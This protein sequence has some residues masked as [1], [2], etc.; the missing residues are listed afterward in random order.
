MP[1][2][3]KTRFLAVC[4]VCA[5]VGL[6]PLVGSAAPRFVEFVFPR[7]GVFLIEG[8]C[9]FPLLVE[10]HGFMRI[11]EYYDSA[12]NLTMVKIDGPGAK[13]T[14]TNVETGFS[15]SSPVS[16]Q[17]ILIDPDRETVVGLPFRLNVPGSGIVALD[18][19]RVIFTADGEVII[20][21]PHEVL[22]N[23]FPNDEVCAGFASAPGSS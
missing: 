8:E 21:G 1:R 3:D 13:T 10:E 7:E 23:G 17:T 4:L 14:F 16:P 15:V 9:D 22:Q 11:R 6:L 5:V 19:G 20:H 2:R 12:G 18:A